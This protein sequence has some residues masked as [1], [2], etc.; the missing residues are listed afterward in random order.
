MSK[1][2][3]FDRRERTEPM[4]TYEGWV[5]QLFHGDLDVYWTAGKVS[6]AMWSE[7]PVD[8]IRFADKDS[9]DMVIRRLA[10]GIGRAVTFASVS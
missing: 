7:K 9:A 1:A 10:G 2:K 8:A 3:P 6:G 4:P 5:I